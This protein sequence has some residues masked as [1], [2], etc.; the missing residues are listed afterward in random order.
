M[1]QLRTVLPYFRPYRAALVR[2]L[3]LVVLANAFSLANPY[4]LKLPIDALTAGAG[5]DP[6]AIRRTVVT[7]ALLIVGVALLGNAARYGMREIMN[8]LSRARSRS[9][10]ATTS[11]ATCCA[12]TPDSTAAPAPAS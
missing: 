2:G 11:C 7:Y 3:L 1:R 12:W 9:T 6:D 4:L 5:A 8:G 10:C